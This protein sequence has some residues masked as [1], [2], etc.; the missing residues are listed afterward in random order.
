V[1]KN[2]GKEEKKE[3]FVTSLRWSTKSSILSFRI[4]IAIY[5]STFILTGMLCGGG[6]EFVRRLCNPVFGYYAMKYW[7]SIAI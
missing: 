5:S 3:K 7:Y 6:S 4:S 2:A 1:S